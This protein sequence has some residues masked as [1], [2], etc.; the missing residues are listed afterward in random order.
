[1][2]TRDNYEEFFLLYTDNE[3]SAVDVH[4]VERFVADHPDLREELEA[5]LQCKLS[6]DT[7]LAFPDQEALLNREPDGSAETGAS[8]SETG[9]P[10]FY[11]DGLPFLHP[12]NSIVFPDKD[13][14]YRNAKERRIIPLPW[15]R[16]GIAAAVIT[17]I[18]LVFLLTGR[19]QPARPAPS[20]ASR[21]AT[22][23]SVAAKLPADRNINPVVTSTPPPALHLVVEGQP[24]TNGRQPVRKPVQRRP[25]QQQ[26]L[27]VNRNPDEGQV[28]RSTIDG[29]QPARSTI[30]SRKGIDQ[31]GPAVAAVDMS[32]TG[33][34]ASDVHFAVQT[35]IPKDQSSFATQALQE[36]QAAIG[37]ESDFGT[38]EP[39][40]PARTKLRGIFRKVTRAFAKTA[41]RDNEGNR[42]VL[43][44][45]FQVTLN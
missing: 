22:S 41:D 25:D 43:V 5:L 15:L 6:P 14:L 35:G 28:A 2:I 45:A 4:A 27:A 30:N 18:A 37:R 36:E 29:G 32:V 12:D 42:Q 26:H 7:H 44:G 17:A 23:T 40:A 10:L 16:T 33:N 3:L 39:A 20:V 34:L 8:L 21:A 19:Q 24:K 9:A 38:D 11:I 13:R 1:M 31:P